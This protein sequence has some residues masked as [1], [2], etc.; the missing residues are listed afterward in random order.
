M[1]E[2]FLALASLVEAGQAVL[3]LLPRY[4]L[5]LRRLQRE[6]RQIVL[7]MAMI[8]LKKSVPQR[9]FV[10]EEDE[11]ELHLCLRPLRRYPLL[12][13]LPFCL[14]LSTGLLELQRLVSQ[15]PHS[16]EICMRCGLRLRP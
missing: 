2:R 4:R 1:L 10:A 11:E 12:G 6:W 15:M 8:R 16:P 7:M 9:Q 5:R 14:L 13:H 3:F